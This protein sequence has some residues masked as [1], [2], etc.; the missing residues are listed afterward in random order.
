MRLKL[1]VFVILACAAAPTAAR[2]P[3]LAG[4]VLDAASL[5]NVKTYC[6]DTSNLKGPLNATVPG[7]VPQP[8][9]FDVNE[10]I[11]TESEPK[12]L[13]S[14]LPW[15]LE[16]DCAAPGVDAIVRFDF[17]F[18]GGIQGVVS[19]GGQDSQP[20][21]PPQDY[22]RTDIQVSDKASSRAIYKAEG[23]PVNYPLG[24]TTTTIVELY[25][26]QRQRAAYY[27]MAALIS[28]LK[29]ISRNP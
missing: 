4:K 9:T 3:K 16:A 24:R 19:A 17:R 25:H 6:V 10:F 13:L 20:Q 2:R 15:K 12:G 14:K 28:D 23:N 11:G 21:P 18:Q 22:W 8:E 26:V 5:S 27:A 1:W 7:D 29:A